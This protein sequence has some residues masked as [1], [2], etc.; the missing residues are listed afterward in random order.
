MSAFA[1]VPRHRERT[2]FPWPALATLALAV[3]CAPRNIVPTVECNPEQDRAAILKMVGNYRVEF[4]FDETVSLHEGYALR[5]PYRANATEQVLV[6]E[7]TPGRVSLQHIL[8]V[9][10][11]GKR[12]PLKH[13]RQDWTFEDTELL[14]FR[15]RR[16]W[17]RRV[18]SSDEARCTWSQA[19]FEVDDGPRYEGSGR[20][21]HSRGLSAWE[22]RETWRPLPRR[23]YTKRSDYDALVGTNRHVMTPTGWVH[24]QDSLKVVLGPTQHALARERGVNL[25]TRQPQEVSLPEADAY[26]TQAQD[27]WGEVRQGWQAVFQ[28]HSGF[29]LK[30]S[31]D[32]KARTE[33]LFGLADAHQKSLGEGRTG[34]PPETRQQIRSTLESFL[35]PVMSAS[36]APAAAGR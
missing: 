1:P 24:E 22:S 6:L 34:V 2:S 11:D 27:F 15:G 30:D 31:V 32:G 19:V 12:S 9:E 25:Y 29:T 23:E 14:E 7:D 5:A 4:A 8:V 36:A 10:R 20:W 16:S 21:N 13:W 35:E 17:E 28:A 33:L 3:A 26:W 18:L